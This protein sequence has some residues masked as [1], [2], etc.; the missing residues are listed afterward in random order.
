MITSKN[1][2]PSEVEV[3]LRDSGIGLNAEQRARIF[4]AFYTTKPTGMGMG[5]SI[6][7]SILNSHEGRLW[8]TSNDEGGTTFHFSLP[9]QTNKAGAEHA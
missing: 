5:L 7:R 1:A 3:M 6:C 2:E 8:A 9:R 4:D